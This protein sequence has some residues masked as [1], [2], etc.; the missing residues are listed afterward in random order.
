MYIYQLR[1]TVHEDTVENLEGRARLC[2]GALERLSEVWLVAKMVHNM[3][4]LLLDSI[5]LG[6]LLSSSARKETQKTSRL[7]ETTGSGQTR[8]IPL[9]ATLTPAVSTCRMTY[10]YIH[11]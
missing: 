7:S 6:H 1:A 4:Q 5:S 11:S 8:L 2:M 3:F 9:N 10:I